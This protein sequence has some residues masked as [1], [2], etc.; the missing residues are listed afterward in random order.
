[1]AQFSFSSAAPHLC[2]YVDTRHCLRDI[3]QGHFPKEDFSP[4]TILA[5]GNILLPQTVANKRAEL[6]ITM[7]TK[8]GLG[9]FCF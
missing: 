8:I 2:K 6:S 4:P 5:S 9:K 1:M 3:C 7:V